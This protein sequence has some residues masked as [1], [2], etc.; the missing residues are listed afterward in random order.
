MA[1]YWRAPR[2]LARMLAERELTGS[3]YTLLHFVAESGAD[4]PE[5]I[6]TSIGALV[7]A[8]GVSDA[9]IRR[10]LKALRANGLIDYATHQGAAVF[11]VRTGRKLAEDRKSNV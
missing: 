9:T 4:R 11:T 8:L 1:G 5:G 3:A 10:S 7:D 2:A 6:A